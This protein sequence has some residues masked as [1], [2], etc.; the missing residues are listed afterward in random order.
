M[1][2]TNLFLSGKSIK[3]IEREFN[4]ELL[5]LD[6]WFKSNLLSLNLSK[7]SYIIFGHKKYANLDIYFRGALL[8]RQHDTK[9]LG[10]ILSAKL[11]WN[12]H[13]DMVLNKTSKCLGIISKVRHIIPLQLTRMLYLTLVEPYINYC[14]LVWCLP[15]NTVLLDKILKI[16]KRY[17]RLLTFS[18]YTAHSQPLFAQLNLLNIYDIYQ[19]QL[20]TYMY[21][22]MNNHIPFLDHHI[23]ISGSSIHNHDTRFKHD[24]RKPFCRTGKRQKAICFQG[25]TLWNRLSDDI[26]YAPSLCIFKNKLRSFLFSN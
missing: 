22:I 10:V 4:N 8:N 21:K 16:Q 23:F 14:N 13:I 17:C 11:T 1:I 18:I 19:F 3:Q 2:G 24:L 9:F 26:R 12:K 6:E 5:I 7:T 25:P 20:A 15:S